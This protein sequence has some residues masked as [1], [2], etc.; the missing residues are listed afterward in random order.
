MYNLLPST[1][2]IFFFENTFRSNMAGNG[3]Q[4]GPWGGKGGVNPWT[5][6]PSGRICEICISALG[7]VDSIRFTYKDRDNVKH[8]S[9]TYGGDGGSSHTFTFADD[10]NL[11]EI[12]GTVGVY[13]GYTVI[14]SLSFLTNTKKYGPYGTTQGTSFSLPV[15][16]GSFGGF[17]GNYGDYLDSFSVILH[18]Y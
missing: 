17:S 11:I 7:C 18:P 10:K 4:V 6:I 12:S 1:T 3:V 13:G 2:F 15:A 5:F 8:H 14:T 16:K 9:E